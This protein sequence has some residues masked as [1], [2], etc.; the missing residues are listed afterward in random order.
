MSKSDVAVK[1]LY[2]LKMIPNMNPII[3][4]LHQ[5]VTGPEEEH[6]AF[7]S[8]DANDI[9]AKYCLSTQSFQTLSNRRT[10]CKTNVNY[11]NARLC[12]LLTRLC[13]GGLVSSWSNS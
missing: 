12:F 9:E 10:D 2:C 3:A 8:C 4:K 6:G 7:V 13:S 11:V 5:N 1:D